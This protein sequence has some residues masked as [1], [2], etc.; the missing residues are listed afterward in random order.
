MAAS[1]VILHGW[2]DKSPSFEGLRTFLS[3]NGW[4]T[5]DV[6]LTDYISLDD[7]VRIEDVVKR[8][9][10]V[11]R[12]TITD[13][14]VTVPFDLIVHS[15]GGLVA[16]HWISTFFPD[17]VAAD[18][19][20]CPVKRLVMLAP[21]NFGSCLAS[22]GKSMIGRLVKGWNNWFQTGTEMLTALELAS[23][24]QWELAQRDLFDRGKDKRRAYGPDRVWPFVIVGTR[25][26]QDSLAQIANEAGSD[27]TVRAAAANMNAFGI[28]IDFS[29]NIK[30][31]EVVPWPRRSGDLL[32]PLAVLPDRDHGS[33][34]EPGVAS[35]AQQALSDRL[36]QLIIE[37]LKCPSDAEYAKI[38]ERWRTISEGTHD[39]GLDPAAMRTAFNDRPPSE[40]LNCF[41]QYFQVVVSVRDDE[42]QPVTDYFVEFFNSK[43][44]GDAEAIFFHREVLENVHVN[45]QNAARRCFFIDRDDLM[46]GYY[47]I[48][49]KNALRQV[50]MSI[51]AAKPGRNVTYFEKEKVGATGTVV[52]HRENDDERT[53]LPVR[54]LRNC[55]HLVEIIIP[56][57][58][59][60][61]V[62][63]I[64]L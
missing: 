34:H 64:T 57:T 18:G 22:M 47:P 23:S 53:D 26:Y 29:K 35:G 27:G 33:V 7:D 46:L 31:P 28:T 50:E 3:Q 43:N 12:K 1:V 20:K 15:T 44:K 4:Q 55:T 6:R 5:A 10:E 59:I 48:L 51:S 17:G 39:L 42:G 13:K 32:F 41:H 38:E 40:G 14:K 52:V 58:P 49:S 54:L 37:A 61:K 2:S 8:M 16:R 25:G 56:R 36:G 63:T 30:V 11:V 45:G 19:M 62:F 21:A 60:D 24:L 9:D